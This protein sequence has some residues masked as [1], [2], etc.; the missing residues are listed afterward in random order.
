MVGL[1]CV[2]SFYLKGFRFGVVFISLTLSVFSTIEGYEVTAGDILFYVE[3]VVVVW[4]GS[5]FVLRCVKKK[6]KKK[7]SCS[8]VNCRLWSSGC[9]SRYQGFLGRLKF[10][11]RPFCIIGKSSGIF[12]LSLKLPYF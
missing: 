6:I 3:S 12:V 5:E 4:F 2:F 9:R 11:R 10:L 8:C 7:E 1:F